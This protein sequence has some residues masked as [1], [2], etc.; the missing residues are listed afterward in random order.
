MD[1]TEVCVLC[2]VAA[3]GSEYSTADIPYLDK[4]KYFEYASWL[5]KYTSEKDSLMAMRVS[6]ALA[7]CLILR[8]SAS[9]R[10]ITGEA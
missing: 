1:M 5:L 6:A 7:L 2:A 4:M 10:T 8:K 3:V 9:A